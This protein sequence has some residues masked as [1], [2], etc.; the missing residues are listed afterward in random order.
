MRLYACWRVCHIALCGTCAGALECGLTLASACALS[1]CAALRIGPCRCARCGCTL[2]GACALSLHAAP[3]PVRSMRLDAC[4]CVCLCGLY[5]PSAKPLRIARAVMRVYPTRI[6]RQSHGAASTHA[7][8]LQSDQPNDA[9]Q[10]RQ[11]LAT[12]RPSDVP[13]ALS[14]CRHAARQAISRPCRARA[15][16]RPQS[17]ISSCPRCLSAATP[18]GRRSAPAAAARSGWSL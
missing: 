5:Q 1:L 7:D 6:P 9:R 4:R 11:R 12:R 8:A 13:S 14:R 17:P 16:L 15:R 10:C 2:T 18:R 3:V